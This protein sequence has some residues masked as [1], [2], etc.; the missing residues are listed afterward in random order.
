MTNTASLPHVEHASLITA[1]ELA[2]LLARK[3]VITPE[4]FDDLVTRAFVKD[5]AMAMT[6]NTWQQIKQELLDFLPPKPAPTPP[7]TE[8]KATASVRQRPTSNSAV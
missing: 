4:E 8:S 2:K 5:R 7:K 6:E 3:G 1:G